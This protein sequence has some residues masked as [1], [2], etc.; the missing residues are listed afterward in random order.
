MRL[1]RVTVRNLLSFAEQELE[2]NPGLVVIVGPNG[3]GKSN[4]VRLLALAGLAL[5]WL[6]ERSSGMPQPGRVHQAQS[7]LASFAAGRHRG[8]PDGARLRLEVG[9]QLDRAELDDLACFVRAAIVSSALSRQHNGQETI[10]AWAEEQITSESLEALAHGALVVEHQGATDAPWSVSYEFTVDG[11]RFAWGL[12]SPDGSQVIRPVGE[13][14]PPRPLGAMSRSGLRW[15]VPQ[16]TTGADRLFRRFHGSALGCCAGRW[17][18]QP[19]H[20]WYS[21]PERAS[22]L[23]SSHTAGSRSSLESRCGPSRQIVCTH[24]PECCGWCSSAAWSCLASSSAVS[25]H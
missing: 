6:E 5:E 8:M 21:L 15:S 9:L 18:R 25:R 1:T 12:A 19:R 24:W 17:E 23:T 2:L 4:L 14:T 20:R 3:A 16:V 7:A 11:T 10:E 22:A 13:H